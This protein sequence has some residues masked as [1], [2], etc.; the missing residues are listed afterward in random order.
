MLAACKRGADVL[1]ALVGILLC[2]PLFCLI[3]LG[4]R[5]T[6]C[7]PIFFRQ[8]RMGRDLTPFLLCKFRTMSCSAPHDAP[9]AVIRSSAYITPFGAF[10][11]RTSLDELPQLYN[12]LCGDMSIIGPRP[13][14]LSEGEL[15]AR[16]ADAGVYRVRPGLSGLAQV[17]GRDLLND[18]EKLSLDRLYVRHQSLLFDL[19]LILLS[20]AVA[21]RGHGIR[22]GKGS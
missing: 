7:G 22:E 11:R 9:T 4:I 5:L 14:V 15:I 8:V 20:L 17:L 10:L 18:T 16:R 21:L 12:I 2:L 1:L 13:V 19:R 3:A 6:S